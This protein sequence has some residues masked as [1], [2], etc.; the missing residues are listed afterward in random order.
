[1]AILSRRDS[2]EAVA[3]VEAHLGSLFDYLPAALLM[4]DADG[5][6]VRT[7]AEAERVLRRH[8]LLGRPVCTV[9]PFV[10]AQ[11][12]SEVWPGS[13]PGPDEPRLKARCASIG[14]PPSTIRIYALEDVAAAGSGWPRHD[15]APAAARRSLFAPT[16]AQRPGA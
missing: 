1:M 6:I 3:F 5:L 11:D 12:G 14:C 7:N 13:L 15:V 9:L 8:D 4:T 16:R 10:G 2:A